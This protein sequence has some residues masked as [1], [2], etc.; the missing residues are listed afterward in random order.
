[1]VSVCKKSEM[2]MEGMLARGLRDDMIKTWTRRGVVGIE[3]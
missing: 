1:M 3:N 2:I